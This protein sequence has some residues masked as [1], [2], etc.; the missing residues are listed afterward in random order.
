[1]IIRPVEPEDLPVINAWWP[2]RTLPQTRQLLM[3]VMANRARQRGDGFLAVVDGQRC[4][5]GM[6]TL[7]SRVAEISD[8]VVDP[9]YRGQGIGTAL[10]RYLCEVAVHYHYV[11]VEIG[12]MADNQPAHR[13]YERLGFVEDRI[14]QHQFADSLH[15]IIY[16]QRSLLNGQ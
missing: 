7:W 3:R 2:D 5:F 16:L 6:I 13:L 4:G 9:A 8:L 1:M 10:I 12:V 14:I 11:T 15:D